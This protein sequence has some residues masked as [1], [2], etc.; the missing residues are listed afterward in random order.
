MKATLL[1]GTALTA[2]MVSAPAMAQI[3]EIVITAQKRESTLL[4]T[5]IAVSAV[6]GEEISRAQARDVRDISTLVP[7]LQ[8]NT[9]ASSTNT[10]FSIRQIGSTTFNFGVE[11]AV[12]VFV[13]GVYRARNGAS[14]NDFLGLER[15]EVLRGPQSTLFGKNT[16]A[17]VINFV[18]QRPQLDEW[19]FEGEATYGNFDA[20]VFKGSITGPIVEDVL[21]IR[22]DGNLNKRDGF[23]TNLVDGNDVNNR[24]RYG[25]RGQVLYTPSD[26]LEVRLIADYNDID[27]NCCAAG[28]VQYAP[29]SEGLIT[30]FGGIAAPE[31]VFEREIAIDG[32]EDGIRA[33]VE[34]YG[35]SGQVDWE[36]DSG[37]LT[38]I[39]AYRV[40][41]ENQTIDS[42]FVNLELAT[43]NTTIQGY[44]TFTQEI[45][46]ASPG[47]DE[48]DW[49][50]GAYY[51]TQ[52]L[53]TDNNVVIAPFA[54][55]FFDALTGNGITG[56]ENAL[57]LP[58][59]T[60]LQPGTGIQQENYVQ[61]NE[62][63]AFFAQAD[64]HI[65]DRFTIT[66]GLRYTNDSKD[67]TSDIIIDDAFAA[68][69][70]VGLG[71][72]GISAATGIPIELLTDPTNFE[73]GTLPPE[74][75]P[76]DPAV[77]PAVGLVPFQ[78]FPPAANVQDLPDIDGQ[79]QSDRRD[80]ALTGNIILAY[81]LDDNTNIYAS[82]SRGFKAGG[83][84]LDP[85]SSRAGTA[86]FE[87]ETVDAFEVGAKARL[88]DNKL[89]IDTAIFRQSVDDFQNFTFVGNSFFPSNAS[90]RVTGWELESV[91]APTPE[92]TITGAFTWL[93][94]NEFT[95]FD[96]APCPI[97]FQDIPGCELTLL[98]GAISATPVQDGTG[99]RQPGSPN[100][101][102]V[103][104]ANYNTPI[105]DTI[106]FFARAEVSYTEGFDIVLFDPIQANDDF[107]LVGASIGLEG[108][109]GDWRIQFWGRNIFDEEFFQSTFSNTVGLGINGYPNDPA[110]YG[111]TVSF[112]Y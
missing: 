86:T 9:F 97:N 21:A 109:E 66:G 65:S 61:N 24:D 22:L 44:D 40:F 50:V 95:E 69:D 6:G 88:F 107:L 34:N 90:I 85:G 68:V 23:V 39:T 48:V 91:W 45:R 46:F 73:N 77:N 41:D 79:S 80:D 14:I 83:F 52:D 82:Y 64:W 58:L 78:F 30:A 1:A 17:G 7:S 10:S 111:V 26:T 2:L 47:G 55:P 27:E 101:T 112:S 28:F 110:T 49:I 102:A 60:F 25:L 62:T 53:D 98:P 56:I 100:F 92:L 20:R 84:S 72:A 36:T 57:G 33:Q 89:S 87:P 75:N 103:S 38:S 74:V 15:A 42:D 106:N 32:G 70:L 29:G 18:T 105:T 16:T 76:F 104:T 93:W 37:T 59:G 94:E 81:D 71:A 19:G 67:V 13:D 11:P 4:D 3:E 12:G 51:F 54:R 99:L 96:N 31:D 108:A 63:F 43:P 35:F 8:V 5:P